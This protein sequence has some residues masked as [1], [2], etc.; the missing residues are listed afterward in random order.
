MV[1]IPI[2]LV[3][4]GAFGSVVDDIDEAELRRRQPSARI[5]LVREADHSIQGDQPVELAGL[6]AEFAN[7]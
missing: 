6:L 3:R 4:G 5:Q 7:S 1:R 2:M